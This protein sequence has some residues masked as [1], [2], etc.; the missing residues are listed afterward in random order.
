MTKLADRV[1]LIT[2]AG[3]GIGRASALRLAQE[4]AAVMCADIDTQAADGTAAMIEESGGRSASVGLDVSDERQVVDS[5]AAT[6]DRLGGLDVLFNNAGVGG[7]FDWDRTVAVNLS[8]V[9]YGVFHGARLMAERGGGTIINTASIAG[10]VGLT[11]PTETPL[12]EIEP[13]AGAYIAAKHGVVGLTKQYA[14]TFGRYGVRVNAIA[15][16]YIETPMT[17]EFREDPESEQYLVGLHPLGRL[18]Q[19]S[20]I[21]SAG[22]VSG[23]R[24]RQLHQRHRAARRRRL[25]RALAPRCRACRPSAEATAGRQTSRLQAQH[26]GPHQMRELFTLI[27][28]ERGADLEQLLGD[29]DLQVAFYLA[30]RRQRTAQRVDGG[31]ASLQLVGNGVVRLLEVE[32][33]L[34]AFELDTLEAGSQLAPLP[35]VQVEV[36]AQVA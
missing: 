3:S 20:E 19:P 27:R 14:V 5:L 34:L 4:G 29:H 12:D 15:P 10:L 32:P 17:A 36:I 18:G 26:A 6:V 30:S 35:F 24:R 33:G 7:G 1:A 11:G 2:G 22:G 23:Q 16:G 21:A 8:G 25:H 31:F 28:I 13:S 9:Y